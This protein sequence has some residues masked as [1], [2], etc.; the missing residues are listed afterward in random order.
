LQTPQMRL[1][2][3]ELLYGVLVGSLAGAFLPIGLE[4][5]AGLGTSTAS[6]VLA[7]LRN[8]RAPIVAAMLA[9]LAL[10]LPRFYYKSVGLFR[11]WRAGIIRGV[12]LVWALSAC[13]FWMKRD[14]WPLLLGAGAIF[15]I[16][17]EVAESR[18]KPQRCTAKEIAEWVPRSSR[19]S[20]SAIAFD[21]PIEGWNQDAV[22]RQDFVE[23]VLARVLIDCEPA[24]GITADFGE[25][26]RAMVNR[27]HR[28]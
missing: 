21:K 7:V 10:V 12:S 24:I 11:S 22:G 16:L 27:C 23:T 13:A 17:T 20:V 19:S 1:R 2:M 5:L 25:G 18:R 9:L 4:W 6:R 26:N 3:R 14:H 28:N 15:Q 8:H